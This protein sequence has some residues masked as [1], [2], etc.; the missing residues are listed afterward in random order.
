MSEHDERHESEYE[1]QG[2]GKQFNGY[3]TLS[4]H[5]ERCQKALLRDEDTECQA[6]YKSN[7]SEED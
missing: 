6:P 7:G 3:G 2:C 1:C 4:H 5:T